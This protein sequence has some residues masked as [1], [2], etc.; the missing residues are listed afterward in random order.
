MCILEKSLGSIPLGIITFQNMQV[1]FERK[2]L[3][4]TKSHSLI[5]FYIYMSIYLASSSYQAQVKFI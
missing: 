4:Q 2:M 1:G 5:T 3:G